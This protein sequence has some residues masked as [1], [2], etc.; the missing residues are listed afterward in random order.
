MCTCIGEGKG[1]LLQYSCLENPRDRG[2]W[3]AACLR[4]RTGL[5]MTEATEQQLQQAS[6]MYCY[7]F[8][9]PHTS[10]EGSVPH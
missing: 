7:D 1:N 8:V 9:Q 5:D 10:T 4:V 6:K 3:W 2:A